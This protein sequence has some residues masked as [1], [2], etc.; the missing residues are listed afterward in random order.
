MS[1]EFNSM[2]DSIYGDF[3]NMATINNK[4]RPTHLAHYTSIEALEKIIST[5]E[6]LFSNPL[7]MND[8]QE[9][10]FGIFEGQKIMSQ[11]GQDSR[12]LSS[13]GG[14][15]NFGVISKS[16]QEAFR[17]FDV[18][19]S[20]DVYV[21]CLSEYDWVGQPDGR[22]SMWR[23]YG[24]NGQGAAIVF[25]TQFI[26]VVP[27]SPLLIAKVNYAPNSDRINWINS[28]FNRCLDILISNE[29]TQLNLSI[30][31]ANMFQ[32]MLFESLVSKNPG[33][34]EEEEWR[35][36]YMPDRD[37]RDLMKDQKSYLRRNNTLEPKLRFPIV[38]L[39]LEPRQ[40]WTT[41]S[42]IDRIVFGPTHASALAI[43]SA[44]RMFESLD[45]PELKN[46]IW[47]SEI[48]YRPIGN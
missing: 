24:A 35:I 11:L 34:K 9:M 40:T 17:N 13:V 29:I 26:T 45:K 36:I 27:D 12:V 16:Y 48:P 18:N 4:N 19:H 38:P 21:F 31:G 33:F 30:T 37:V 42:I 22:L 14:L 10:R 7:F 25:N 20:F 3:I 32:L 6:L 23:G 5:N 1:K 28:A 44:K 47:V 41:N 39:N 15:D 8:F 43:N 46:K 2:F